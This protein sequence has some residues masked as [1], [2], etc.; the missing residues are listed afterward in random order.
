MRLNVASALASA[1]EAVAGFKT[2]PPSTLKTFIYTGNKLYKMPWPH[3]LYFGMSK[4]AAAHM[5]WDCSVA[6]RGEY[7]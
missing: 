7:K 2:L 5:V 6:Y 4:S 1:R 3:V